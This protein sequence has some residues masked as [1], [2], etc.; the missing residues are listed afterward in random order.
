LGDRDL[1]TFKVN[2]KLALGN[3][4]DVDNHLGNWINSAYR[5]LTSKNYSPILGR[6]FIFPNLENEDSQDTAV[7]VAYVDKP[8]DC[9]FVQTIDDTTTDKKLRNIS[10]MDYIKKTGRAS[11]STRTNPRYWVTRGDYIYL[12]PTPDGTYSLK[13]YYRK[14]PTVLSGDDA[15]TDIGAEWDD[16][17]E[18]LAIYQSYMRLGEPDKA[19]AYYEFYMNLVSDL[20]GVYEREDLDRESRR[21]PH[22]GYYDY[23]SWE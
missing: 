8:S 3:R 7:G 11:S 9:L 20:L 6:K 18:N 4:D 13:I 21:I 12:F 15:V 14:R 23:N 22:P 2:V 5:T 16:I 10:W 1:S 17:L 19:K